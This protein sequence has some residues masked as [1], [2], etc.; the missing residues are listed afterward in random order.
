MKHLGMLMLTTFAATAFTVSELADAARLG[1]GRSIGAQ[2]HRPAAPGG[3]AERQYRISTGNAG[4]TRCCLAGKPPPS[5][6][7]QGCRAGSRPDRR[8]RGWIGACRAAVAFRSA[9][10]LGKFSGD[11]VAGDRCHLRR[12]DVALAAYP[13]RDFATTNATP[14]THAI[15]GSQQRRWRAG[16]W[17]PKP[18]ASRV[19][20]R[21]EVEPLLPAAS[22]GVATSLAKPLPPGLDV[23]G[24]VAQAKLQFNRLQAVRHR[25][26]QHAV[27]CDDAGDVRRSRTRSVD[28]ARAA[29]DRDRHSR[30][31]STRGDDRGRQ[32][33]GECAYTGLLREDGE[34]L[35][36]PI[37]KSGTS[38]NPSPASPV[39]CSRGFSRS[40]KSKYGDGCGGKPC[41]SCI[42]A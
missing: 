28:A 16:W 5:R 32:P 33:L 17:L 25:R 38:P 13:E 10:G 8:H 23:E 41:Q 1:A 4:A 11:C 22:D 18:I 19:G 24:F 31:R 3:G 42:R 15:C 12:T 39:G 26:S 35:P 20:W 9:R 36:K 2:R 14:A 21:A 7:R 30:R 27:G 34:P 29:P 40:P 37:D 6:G